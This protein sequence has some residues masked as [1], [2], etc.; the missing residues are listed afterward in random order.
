MGP[1]QGNTASKWQS[2]LPDELTSDLSHFPAQS[3]LY[4]TGGILREKSLEKIFLCV[5]KPKSL[6]VLC[7]Y[8]PWLP[9]RR[10]GVLP[11]LLPPFILHP[12]LYPGTESSPTFVHSLEQNSAHPVVFLEPTKEMVPGPSTHFSPQ[13]LGSWNEGLLR[14]AQLPLPSPGSSIATLLS[15]LFASWG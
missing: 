2:G 6:N 14:Q 12:G 13:V 9:A 11:I 8:H 10:T 7:L 3:L 1:A 4:F 15:M 5:L